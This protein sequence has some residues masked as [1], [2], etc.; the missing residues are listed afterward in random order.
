MRHTT[1]V[2]NS[3]IPA[4]PAAAP[5]DTKSLLSLERERGEGT[6]H[7]RAV[8]SSFSP[9]EALR[10]RLMRASPGDLGHVIYGTPS[11]PKLN[12]RL[13][14]LS[15][16]NTIATTRNEIV[17]ARNENVT[18]RNE[19]VTARNE[20]VTARNENVT[21]RNENVTARNE[22]V[23]ARNENVTARNENVTVRNENV[24][25]RNENVTVRNE[26]V[27]ARNENVT[28]RNENV[29]ARN[30]NVTARRNFEYAQWRITRL[31]ARNTRNTIATRV[32]RISLREGTS[33]TL[34]TIF[35]YLPGLNI[36]FS[37]WLQGKIW[38]GMA[39]RPGDKE[40]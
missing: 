18:A 19:I 32:M 40:G 6:H 29:T 5:L 17:T 27:T 26:N 28:A 36:L 39:M 2:L 11:V 1:Q 25:A 35:A 22:I 37:P 8:C 10:M 21:A 12:I 30:E 7:K 34:V 20:N 13:R 33:N 14:R 3:D 23:T 38:A 16:R 9:M 31:S 4:T 15:A 24:T